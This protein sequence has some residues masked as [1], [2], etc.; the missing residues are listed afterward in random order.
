MKAIEI[1]DIK[2]EDNL[3]LID[4]DMPSPAKE[5]VLIKVAYASVNRPDLLQRKGMHPVPK[6][7]SPYPG[8]DVAGT[9]AELGEATDDFGLKVGDE[10]CALLPGGGYAQYAVA[11]AALCLPKPTNLSLQEAAAL[12]ECVYTVWNNL[13]VRGGLKKGEIALIH[14][15]TSGI[16]SFAIQMAKAAGAK[17]I[18]TAGSAEKCASCKELGADLAINYKQDDFEALIIDKYGDQSVNVVLDMVGGEYLNKNI[19]LLAP[20]GRHVNIAFLNGKVAPVDIAQI[21]QKRLVLTGS[22]LRTRPLAEKAA[23]A[24]GLKE[25]VWPWIEGG[26][27]KPHIFAEFPLENVL[28]AHELMKKSQ[29]IGKIILA[30]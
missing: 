22:T 20:E 10:V 25:T 14:G 21:M 19:T 16:G 4:A 7:A 6:G 13:F 27:V 29:H 30:I 18:T 15:G 26:L 2:A 23:L 11:D 9:I 5:Q 24:K 12:P 1:S 28:D 17:V 3:R 8:L